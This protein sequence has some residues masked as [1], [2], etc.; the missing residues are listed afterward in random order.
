[1]PCVHYAVGS[2]V[3]LSRH[4]GPYK[5]QNRVHTLVPLLIRTSTRQGVSVRTK[6]NWPRGPALR[7]YNTKLTKITPFSA[8]FTEKGADFGL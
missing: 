1:M 3:G 6:E 8:G 4:I 5:V 7:K 2:S